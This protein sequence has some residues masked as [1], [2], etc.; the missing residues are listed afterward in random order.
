[1]RVPTDVVIYEVRTLDFETGRSASVLRT[2]ELALAQAFID[3]ARPRRPKGARYVDGI[4]R[5]EP[6]R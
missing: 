6:R 1:M 3:G 2:T 5:H 4:V